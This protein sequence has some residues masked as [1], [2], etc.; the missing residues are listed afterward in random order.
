MGE[1][2]LNMDGSFLAE[3]STMG[4]GGLI[5][6]STGA[7]V[8]GVAGFEGVRNS[9]L[10]ELLAVK[11][12]LHLAWNEGL[13]CESDALEVVS[14]VQDG[15]CSNSLHANATIFF[16]ILWSCLVEIGFSSLI[17]CTGRQIIVQIFWPSM[18]QMSVLD[19]SI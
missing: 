14:L 12:G 11:P 13:I 2:K 8:S 7:W 9:L 18:E 4:V 19:G 15:G 17:M 3:I 10:A 1:F 5:R 16:M 6:S